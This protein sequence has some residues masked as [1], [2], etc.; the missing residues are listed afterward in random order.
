MKVVRWVYNALNRFVR[1]IKELITSL[2]ISIG[3]MMIPIGIILGATK[4]ISTEWVWVIGIIGFG[5]LI[6]AVIQA[7]KEDNRKEEMHRE[8]LKAIR[9][10]NKEK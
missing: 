10:I 9:D 2:A 3:V 1:R 5:S 4:Q 6:W 7:N 8:L